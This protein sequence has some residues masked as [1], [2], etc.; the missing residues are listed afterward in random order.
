MIVCVYDIQHIEYKQQKSKKTSPFHYIQTH[1]KQW[2]I[3]LYLVKKKLNIAILKF[4]HPF[5]KRLHYNHHHQNQI[6]IQ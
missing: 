3:G 5:K 1:L 6:R 4:K 2:P